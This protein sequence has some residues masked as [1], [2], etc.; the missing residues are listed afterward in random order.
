MFCNMIAINVM[1]VYMYCLTLNTDYDKKLKKKRGE[2]VKYE[3]DILID[4]SELFTTTSS[5]SL[6]K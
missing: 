2:L 4:S 3:K 1:N 6:R 5:E